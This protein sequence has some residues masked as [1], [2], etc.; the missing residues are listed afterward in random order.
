[1]RGRSNASGR[2][3]LMTRIGFFVL[4]A[5]SAF[6]TNSGH[7]QTTAEP[8]TILVCDSREHAER[9]VTLVGKNA[10]TALGDVNSEAK[11]PKAC[12]FANVTYER[13]PSIAPITVHSPP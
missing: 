12:L 13:D 3:S 6:S 8:T 11:N 1:M 9:L 10:E 4:A 2:K 7:A 5:L